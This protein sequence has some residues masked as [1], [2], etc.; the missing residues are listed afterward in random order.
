METLKHGPPRVHNGG[1]HP[2]AANVHANRIRLIHVGFA[3]FRVH[4]AFVNYT[5]FVQFY[6]AMAQTAA[7]I[8]NSPLLFLAA[9]E[10]NTICE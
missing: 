4:N 6:W 3:E 1:F 8:A 7:S 2:R 5:H 10:Q 9:K